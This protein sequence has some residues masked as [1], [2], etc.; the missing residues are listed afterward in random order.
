LKGGKFFNGT[1]I[2]S[3]SKLIDFLEKKIYGF[4]LNYLNFFEKRLE[5]LSIFNL[6]SYGDSR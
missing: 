6:D 1:L 2:F 5:V 4:K 3:N